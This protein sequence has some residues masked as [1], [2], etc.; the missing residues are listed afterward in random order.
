MYTFHKCDRGLRN[1][2]WWVVCGPQAAGWGRMVYRITQV[3]CFTASVT[4]SYTVWHLSDDTCRVLGPQLQVLTPYCTVVRFYQL[5]DRP[6][7]AYY[8][9][10]L[11]SYTSPYKVC[12][13]CLLG[14]PLQVLNCCPVLG[15]SNRPNAARQCFP[16]LI[17]NYSIFTFMDYW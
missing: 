6:P 17:H 4:D 5:S 12:K 16:A 14:S 7:V 10:L 3:S 2:S 11:S 1:T 15:L 8:C 9:C 13:C